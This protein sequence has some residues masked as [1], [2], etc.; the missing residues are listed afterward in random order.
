MKSLVL[1][2]ALQHVAMFIRSMNSIYQ[3]I[4]P[5]HDFGRQCLNFI[6]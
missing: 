3:I 4:E 6:R 2:S 5:I 1:E